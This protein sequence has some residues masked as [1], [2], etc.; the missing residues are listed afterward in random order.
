VGGCCLP[1]PL[2]LLVGVSATTVKSLRGHHR[3]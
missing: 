1:I 2:A 3:V